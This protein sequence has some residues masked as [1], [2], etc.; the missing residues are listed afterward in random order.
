MVFKVPHALPKPSKIMGNL[1]EHRKTT[2]ENADKQLQLSA[3]LAR[4]WVYLIEGTER[5]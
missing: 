1:K 3:L 4:L 2:K 5:H